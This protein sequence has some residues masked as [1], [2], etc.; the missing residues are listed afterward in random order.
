MFDVPS[1]PDIAKC[2]I[3]KET[4]LYK[5]APELI[6]REKT[7]EQPKNKKD[8]HIPQNSKETA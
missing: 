4:V 2:I 7:E 6:I 1:T 8:R 3:T 5:K